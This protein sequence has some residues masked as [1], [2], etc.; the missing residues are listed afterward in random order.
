MADVPDTLVLKRDR[1]LDGRL[2]HI[3]VRR[4]L[5]TVVGLVPLLALFNV[6]G[7]RPDTWT[8]QAA[9]GTATLKLY[10]PSRVRGGLLW[11]ARFRITAKQELKQATLVLHPGWLEGMTLNT[12]EPAPVGEAS[13]NGRLSFEL[14]HIPAGQKYTLFMDF[15]VNPTNVGSHSQDVELTDGDMHILTIDRDVTVFP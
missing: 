15:Q 11:Q 13:K 2:W 6:F 14:G 3:W 8:A 7:Q 9:S 12:V 10:A 4:G 5:L 1:D